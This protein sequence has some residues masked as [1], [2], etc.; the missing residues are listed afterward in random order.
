MEETVVTD[1]YEILEI[2]SNASADTVERV[3]RYLARRYHP[4][5]PE[6]GNAQKFSEV[7]KAYEVLRDPAKRAQYDVN[8]KYRLEYSTKLAVEASDK[9]SIEFDTVIQEQLLSILYVKRRRNMLN[10]GVG[11]LELQRLTAC[12]SEHI[13]FHLWYLKESGWIA[14]LENGLLAITVSGVNK[15]A[16]LIKNSRVNSEKHLLT[17]QHKEDKVI[18]L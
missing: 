6:T 17:D 10:P 1:Y 4:D 12:P 9:D 7:V 11:N 2:S 14:R 13:E 5:H 3:F 8:Y 16:M 18:E 15:A